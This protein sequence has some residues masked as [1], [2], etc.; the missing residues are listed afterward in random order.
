MVGNNSFLYIVKTKSNYSIIV[1]MLWLLSWIVN[2]GFLELMEFGVSE[3]LK[4]FT[5]T[6]YKQI[7]LYKNSD[8]RNSI[9]ITKWDANLSLIVRGILRRI[10]MGMINSLDT[11]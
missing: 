11:A 3:K 7:Q 6:M 1:G 9:T 2:K 8:V 5:V 10:L 4:T